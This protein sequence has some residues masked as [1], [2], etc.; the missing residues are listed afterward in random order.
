MESLNYVFG[1]T[2]IIGIYIYVL[3]IIGKKCFAVE[4]MSLMLTGVHDI[5]NESVLRGNFTNTLWAYTSVF[6]IICL[7]KWNHLWYKY[8]KLVGSTLT[9]FYFI[10]IIMSGRFMIFNLFLSALLGLFEQTRTNIHLKRM[11]ALMVLR[12][13]RSDRPSPSSHINRQNAFEE[14]T[15]INRIRETMGKSFKRTSTLGNEKDHLE[16]Q[17]INRFRLGSFLR[18]NHIVNTG[19]REFGQGS[20]DDVIG[21]RSSSNSKKSYLPN[22]EENKRKNAIVPFPI[23]IQPPTDEKIGTDENLISETLR[24]NSMRKNHKVFIIIF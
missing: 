3:A 20:L 24:F 5:E 16:T 17:K 8:N 7:E 4:D 1:F 23:I 15:K 6:Q 2:L 22:L 10:I 13:F 12:T 9:N 21:N 18:S 11:K 14:D 19:E